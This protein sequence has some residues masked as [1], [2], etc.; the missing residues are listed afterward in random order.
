M[1]SK[2]KKI[3]SGDRIIDQI[4]DSLIGS[5]NPVLNCPLIDGNLVKGVSLDNAKDNIIN[6]GLG[7][8]FIGYQRTRIQSAKG[9]TNYWESAT[10]NNSPDKYII[11]NCMD[12]MICDFWIF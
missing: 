10:V 12:S 9:F 2:L 6:H 7:R 8:K 5:I 3:L 4:Q 11:L 1:F